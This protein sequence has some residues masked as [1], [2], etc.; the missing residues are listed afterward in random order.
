MQ[1]ADLPSRR[2]EAWK[3]SDLRAA[4]GGQETTLAGTGPIGSEGPIA[5]FAQLMGDA[6]GPVTQVIE[7]PGESFET[8]MTEGDVG[9]YGSVV[10]KSGATALMIERVRVSGSSLRPIVP[11][12]LRIE[13]EPGAT[14]H[15]VVVQ[16]ND[17]AGGVADAAIVL[18]EVTVKVGAGSTFRQ[19]QLGE[20][21]RLTRI[22]TTVEAGEGAQIELNG[23]YLASAKRHVD[24]TSRVAHAAAGIKT[25]QLVRGV[26]RKGGRGVFQGKFLVERAG[27]KTDADMQHNALLLEEGAEIFA[28][29]ELEIYADDVACAH[30]NTSGQLDEDAIFYLRQRGIPHAEAQA[31]ITRAFL[32]EAVPEW[33]GDDLRAE[34]EARI[35][36]W[37]GAQA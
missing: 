3:W 31:M 32:I 2:T 12:F 13:V 35:D 20:G 4:M 33:M 21:S 26:A 24:F 34:V 17:A 37:L 1:L 36:R 30:G 11:A 27:Q 16:T 5:A 7:A 18:N 28:K 14:L 22:E 19:F 6:Y 25:Q 9:Q 29:P 8:A 10:V 15:R 23:V